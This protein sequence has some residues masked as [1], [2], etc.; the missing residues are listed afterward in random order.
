[1]MTNSKVNWLLIVWFLIYAIVM[2]MLK[3]VIKQ[4]HK[5]QLKPCYD[6]QIN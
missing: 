1:M 4:A 5:P 2:T 6:I 3:N